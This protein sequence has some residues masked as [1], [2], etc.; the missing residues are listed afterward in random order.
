MRIGGAEKLE[1]AAA[2]G[3]MLWISEYINET[4]KG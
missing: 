4:M 1:Q 3:K 2:S